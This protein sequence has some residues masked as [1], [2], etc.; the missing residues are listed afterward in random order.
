MNKFVNQRK[1]TTSQK[2]V[3]AKLAGPESKAEPE[4]ERCY[5]NFEIHEYLLVW[6]GSS[7]LRSYVPNT[8]NLRRDIISKFHE[9][10]HFG[11]AIVYAEACQ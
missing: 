1:K 10:A 3:K 2:M 8:A 6:N 9:S 7:Q 5:R 11:P 4:I